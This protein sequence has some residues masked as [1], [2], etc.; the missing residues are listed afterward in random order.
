MLSNHGQEVQFLSALIQLEEFI[1][2]GSS[3][4]YKR[5]IKMALRMKPND[6]QFNESLSWYLSKRQV[7]AGIPT[8]EW[9]F[10]YIQYIQKAYD[11]QVFPEKKQKLLL[12][13]QYSEAFRDYNTGIMKDFKNLVQLDP[14]PYPLKEAR[15]EIYKISL[16]FD[17]KC[18]F[19]V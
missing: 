12:T 18:K 15:F 1:S 19:L 16:S 4:D 10:S 8:T 17:Y 9:D 7:D 5:Y 6:P 11:N 3:D 14:T 2:Q 13:L